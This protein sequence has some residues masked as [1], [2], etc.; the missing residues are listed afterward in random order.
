MKKDLNIRVSADSYKNLR[1]LSKKE[2]RTIKGMLSHAIEFYID[3][4]SVPLDEADKV[5]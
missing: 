1:K 5:K 2:G 3:I 4:A